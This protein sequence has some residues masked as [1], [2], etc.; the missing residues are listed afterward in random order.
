MIG[1]GLCKLF[2]LSALTTLG[3]ISVALSFSMVF[4]GLAWSQIQN[5]NRKKFQLDKQIVIEIEN[6]NQRKPREKITT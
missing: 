1:Y 5:I 6:N 2:E 3:W 4:M